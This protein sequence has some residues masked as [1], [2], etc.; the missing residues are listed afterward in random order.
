MKGQ[1]QTGTYPSSKRKI[2]QKVIGLLV[3]LVVTNL[4]GRAEAIHAADALE[5]G[6]ATS[7]SSAQLQIHKA[8]RTSRER[9]FNTN[10]AT[11]PLEELLR[12]YKTRHNAC[13]SSKA[14]PGRYI[15]VRTYDWMAGL[16][17]TLPSVVSGLLLA[18]LMER[19]LFVDFH[20]FNEYFTHELDFSWDRHAER[21]LAHGHNAS[22]P[23]N[24]PAPFASGHPTTS[25]FSEVADVWMFRDIPVHYERHYGIEV[26]A[27][28]DWS[29]ALLQSNP[30]HQ[31]FLDKY[32]P[33]REI[34][35]P[36]ASFLLRPAPQYDHKITAFKRKHFTHF[37]IGLQ[38]R[39]RKCDF[40]ELH[41]D[42]RPS[43]ESYCD[44]ARS[45]QLA[46]DVADSD[47]RFFIAA[48]VPETYPQ[49]TKILGRE[50]VIFVE[51]GIVKFSP[52][53]DRGKNPI[54]NPGSLESAL[55]DI[56]LLSQCDDIITTFASSFG[57]V[58]A[59]WGGIAPVHMMFGTHES[60]QN[61][62]WYRALSSEPCYWQAKRLM[63]DISEAAVKRFRS[64]PL[65][66]QYSQCH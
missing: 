33:R 20:F 28:L 14:L 31:A 29:A 44:V 36:L 45:I 60:S 47:V 22:L 57:Y 62:Y 61:P 46:R 2:A 16:G 24:I 40:E 50:R 42:T 8:R 38:I 21:L 19:C 25:N 59:A 7:H 6:P 65:W 63:R 43:I 32:F 41:C 5:R 18:L 66:I 51:D 1:P 3:L 34:F 10:E 35:R 56:A 37:T 48:D 12:S 52:I 49:V 9:N 30:F 15:V 53:R 55:V 58:A 23:E 13:T 54:G 11:E 39:R 26:L 17:N 4:E 27:D 64:N